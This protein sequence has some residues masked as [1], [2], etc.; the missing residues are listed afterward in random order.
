MY[1]TVTGELRW[2]QCAALLNNKAGQ[3]GRDRSLA[4]DITQIGQ[5]RKQSSLEGSGQD[6]K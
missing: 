4:S 1:S 2:D 5:N 3:T 6:R